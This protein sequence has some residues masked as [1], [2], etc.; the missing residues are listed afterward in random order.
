MQ[1]ET[2]LGTPSGSAGLGGTTGGASGGSGSGLGATGGGTGG[3]SGTGSPAGS[4]GSGLGSDLSGG[5]LGGSS[6]L[7]GGGLGETSRGTRTATGTPS[8]LGDVGDLRDTLGQ[9]GERADEVLDQAADHLESAALK[10][11]KLGDRV[12]Q[13]GVAARA[14]SLAHDAADALE[15]LAGFLRDNDVEKFQHDLGRMV[16]T[17]PLTTVV[18]AVGAGWIVGRVLR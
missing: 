18:L 3:V 9:L 10:L 17:R 8:R 6:G 14:G 15:S 4:S 1:D 2:N 12:P 16:S 5:E 7:S 11:D 13:R